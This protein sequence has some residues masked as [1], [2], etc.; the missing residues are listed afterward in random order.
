MDSRNTPKPRGPAS[1]RP[2]GT[3]S[4]PMTLKSELSEDYDLQEVLWQDDAKDRKNG[5]DSGGKLPAE[6]CVVIGGPRSPQTLGKESGSRW[7]R[8]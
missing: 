5:K 4:S 1:Q 7:S 8:H 2:A 3:T 6:I